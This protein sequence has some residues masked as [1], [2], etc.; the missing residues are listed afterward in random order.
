MRSLLHYLFSLAAHLVSF[1]MG[2]RGSFSS[3]HLSR[4]KRIPIKPIPGWQMFIAVWVLQKLW[5]KYGDQVTDTAKRQAAKYHGP[6]AGAIH[7]FA[8]SSKNGDS[9]TV[10]VEAVSQ[11]S[12]A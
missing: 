9:K 5:G 1:G 4:R 8:H 11:Q 10:T 6:G 7:H 2:R 12:E 3:I